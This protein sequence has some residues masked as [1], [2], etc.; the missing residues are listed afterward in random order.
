MQKSGFTKALCSNA[1]KGVRCFTGTLRRFQLVGRFGLTPQASADEE[2]RIYDDYAHHPTELRAALTAA[3][4]ARGQGRLVA[5]FQ[6]HLYSRTRQFATEFGQALAL[7][8]VVVI[9]DVYGAREDPIPGVSGELI[10]Q[11]AREH[12]AADVRYVPD[13]AESSRSEERRV[14]K[15]CRSR[16]SPYH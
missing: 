9:T 11:A 14:G 12:G 10:A 1:R 13:K 5:C 2:I 4:R 7:A 8:D 16:W 6:P 15:E 3:A